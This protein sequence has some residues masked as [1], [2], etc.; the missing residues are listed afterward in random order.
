MLRG[1]GA[2]VSTGA[3]VSCAKETEEQ[4]PLKKIKIAVFV[5]S[6]RTYNSQLEA[7]VGTKEISR[8]EGIPPP[9]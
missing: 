7:F 5:T 1:E 9:L 3:G 6:C 2:A 4:I 8:G